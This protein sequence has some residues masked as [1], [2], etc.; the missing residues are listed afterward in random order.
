MIAHYFHS[1]GQNCKFVLRCKNIYRISTDPLLPGQCA[2]HWAARD[3]KAWATMSCQKWQ[4]KG[5]VRHL[6]PKWK[7]PVSRE[8]PGTVSEPL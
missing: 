3:D 2:D 6:T 8:P 1:L 7:A 5:P 4:G